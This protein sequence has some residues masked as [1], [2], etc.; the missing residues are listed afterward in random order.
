[1]EFLVN[2]PSYFANYCSEVIMEHNR[3]I[4]KERT[5]RAAQNVIDKMKG[6]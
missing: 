2:A 4:Q 6:R 3:S 1:M 5:R